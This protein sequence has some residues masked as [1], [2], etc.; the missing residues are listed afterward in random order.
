MKKNV[1]LAALTLVVFLFAACGGT[2]SSSQ[3]AASKPSSPTGSSPGE[4]YV[5]GFANSSMDE[6]ATNYANLFIAYAE[7]QGHSVVLLDAEN[8]PEKQLSNIEDLIVKGVDVIYTRPV[9][10]DAIVPAI[11]A[12]NEAGI[13]II[14]A[15]FSANT[16]AADLKIAISQYGY[17]GGQAEYLIGQ[18]EADPDLTLHIG[19]IWGSHTFA[20]AQER[21]DGLVEGLQAY[22]DAGRVVIVDEQSCDMS[23]DKAISIVEDWVIRYPE[24][25]CFIGANDDLGNAASNVLMANNMDMEAN[26]VLGI[27]GTEVGLTAIKEGRMDA[28]VLVD[29]TERVGICCQY[30]IDLAA[31]KT[32]D[33]N[34]TLDTDTLIV[35]INNVDSYL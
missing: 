16:D 8:N 23:L 13:P 26:Y 7:E 20:P 3:S 31:G 30:A 9:D 32:V 27:E 12:C 22:I 11:Q 17:G 34:V 1:W 6:F 4:S 28:T 35:D 15:D 25:N 18:L 21:H 14:V 19:Y 5:I 29:I 24:M 10:A 2:A 33:K